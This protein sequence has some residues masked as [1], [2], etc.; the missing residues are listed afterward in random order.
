MLRISTFCT[1]PSLGG[2]PSGGSESPSKYSFGGPSE[3]VGASISAPFRVR[4][5]R[6]R[7]TSTRVA[8]GGRS[9]AAVAQCHRRVQIAQNRRV[10]L[11]TRV[12][13]VGPDVGAPSFGA[14][15][16]LVGGAG[17]CTH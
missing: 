10:K 5:I 1:G 7:A 14:C 9:P 12:S 4:R 8:I 3:R 13:G 2:G 15:L 6:P 17:L 11:H 16:L